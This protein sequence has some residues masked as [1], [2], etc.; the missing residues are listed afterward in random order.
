V[1]PCGAKLSNQ[2]DGKIFINRWFGGRG[3]ASPPKR[4][5]RSLLRFILPAIE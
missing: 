4:S 1:V 3:S 5:L 2:L